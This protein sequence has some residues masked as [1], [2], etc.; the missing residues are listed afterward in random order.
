MTAPVCS[1]NATPTNVY[2]CRPGDRIVATLAAERNTAATAAAFVIPKLR[3]T[4]S[5]SSDVQSVTRGQF[6]QPGLLG[7][8]RWDQIDIDVEQQ[9][10][11]VAPFYGSV[12]LVYEGTSA[13]TVGEWGYNVVVY[14]PP[15]ENCDSPN[16][17]PVDTYPGPRRYLLTQ[18][19]ASGALMPLPN[20]SMGFR[21]Y[22][23]RSGG[24]VLATLNYGTAGFSEI[25]EV[26]ENALFPFAHASSIALRNGAAA[27]MIVSHD[28]MF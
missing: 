18:L 1:I 11:I 7:A 17:I 8:V 13:S 12:S 26:P 10:V 22:T 14:P 3:F 15:G 24:P 6:S 27:D 19:V 2:S 4:R 9:G 16:A 5:Y 25:V 28:V 23:D 20:G 21:V